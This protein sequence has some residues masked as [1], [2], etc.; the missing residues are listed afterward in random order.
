MGGGGG[1]RSRMSSEWSSAEGFGGDSYGADPPTYS[2][3]SYDP[4]DPY[5]FELVSPSH[6]CR[7]RPLLSP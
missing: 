1:G 2:Q 7:W 4:Q 3:G 6:S 5:N